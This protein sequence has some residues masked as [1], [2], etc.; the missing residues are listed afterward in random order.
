MPPRIPL[1]RTY[2]HIAL[3]RSGYATVTASATT[4]APPLAQQT[5]AASPI[6]R[7]PANQ[8][9]S[10]KPPEFRKSQLHRQ[11]TSLLRSSPLV[12]LF[13]HNNLRA[14]EWAGVRREL[15]RALHA[16][17]VELGLAGDEGT[18]TGL[19]DSA[20]I[21]VLQAGLLGSALRVVEFWDP[22]GAAAETVHPTDPRTSSSAPVAL[23]E[24]PTHG[25]SRAA[26]D[27]AKA[28]R[29][30]LE[31]EVLLSGPVAAL[32]FPAVSPQHLKAA[33]CTLAP[34]APDFP[35]P[36]RRVN[37]DYH[38][39]SVISGVSKLMLLGARVEG[40]VFDQAGTRW[41]GGIPGG[42]EGLRGQL[43]AMLQ[44]FG[45]QV[46][47][48]LE[49]ATRSVYFTLEGRKMQMEDEGKPKEDAAPATEEAK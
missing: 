41:V 33:L 43:V 7:H 5:Q 4:P 20:R 1:Q 49:G 16:V 29:S 23:D 32:A 30:R 17:D 14:T 25:L 45:A 6:R 15:H 12:L 13:Q 3:A 11:Y 40:S 44:G 35:A 19:A 10:Y 37:P 47:T 28:R 42:L 8:P 26:H 34:H 21:Q 36:R 22:A 18:G 38:D 24:Q 27:A 39:P 31:L 48:A 2:N 9:P 46:T